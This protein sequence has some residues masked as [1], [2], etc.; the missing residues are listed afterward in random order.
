MKTIRRSVFETN[1]SSMHSISL[2][3]YSKHLATPILPLELRCGEFGWEVRDYNDAQTKLEYVLTSIQY[4]IKFEREYPTDEDYRTRNREFLD[5]FERKQNERLKQAI[6]NSNYYKW[7]VEMLFELH[8][9]ENDELDY[10]NSYFS[11]GYIDHQSVDVIDE[12]WTDDEY[13]FKNNMK[14]FIFNTA[15]NLHTDNDNR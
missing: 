4:R 10:S 9:I 2:T 1:S 3:S 14:D 12:L 15:W 11:F 13:I 5:N 6:M 8:A 7:L